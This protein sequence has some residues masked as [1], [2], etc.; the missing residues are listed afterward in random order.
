[1]EILNKLQGPHLPN[2]KPPNRTLRHLPNTPAVCTQ[3]RMTCRFFDILSCYLCCVHANALII[4][5]GRL[6]YTN[7]LLFHLCVLPRNASLV[8]FRMST[9]P[10][11]MY[12]VGYLNALCVSNKM[13]TTTLRCQKCP[14]GF[15]IRAP[16][17][18]CGAG[19]K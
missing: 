4:I 13:L 18:H 15:K 2:T 5:L 1:M 16:L 7:A 17:K 8:Y 3:N 12:Y 6:A 19:G 9:F 10:Y 11:A 14:E